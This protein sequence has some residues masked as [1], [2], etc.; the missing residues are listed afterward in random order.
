MLVEE[1][2]CL[3]GLTMPAIT[4]GVHV[5]VNDGI[6]D[7]NQKLGGA[8]SNIGYGRE[9]G[10]D[11][12]LTATKTIAPGK[13]GLPGPI[14]AS[15]GVRATQAAQLGFLGFSDEYHATFEGNVVYVAND[16]LALAYE[17]RQK[18]DPYGQIAGLIE[19]EES[20][21]AFHVI[22]SLNEQ[23][24]LCLGYGL[25]GMVANTE[26]NNAW[27]VQLKHNF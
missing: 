19:E 26:V 21:H 14:I 22:A 5:K 16:W 1:G 24:M 6:R 9:N 7:I 23:T 10:T 25:F 2:S 13:L 3:A 4:A 17:F 8:L 18:P 11:F 15:A 20:W 27:C 12:T